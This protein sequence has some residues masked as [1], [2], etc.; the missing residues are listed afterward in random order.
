MYIHQISI[1]EMIENDKT[2]EKTENYRP[3]KTTKLKIKKQTEDL[4]MI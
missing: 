2:G 1:K 4:N 3:I